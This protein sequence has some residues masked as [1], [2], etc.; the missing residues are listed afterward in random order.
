MYQQN[1]NKGTEFIIPDY[2]LFDAGAFGFAKKSFGKLDMSGGVRYD[3]RSFKNSQ[4][5]TKPNPT[6]GFDMEVNVPDTVGATQVFKNYSHVFSGA[7]G[8]FGAT[9][10][11]SN[12]FLVK[13]N[14]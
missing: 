8:S 5:F 6:D 7:S 2:N 9:Y 12:N 14:V 4:M 13:A 1:K 3:V 10:N 11:F